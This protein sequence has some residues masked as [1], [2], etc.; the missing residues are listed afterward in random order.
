[1]DLQVSHNP[2]LMIPVKVCSL[3]TAF[4]QHFLAEWSLKIMRI[5]NSVKFECTFPNLVVEKKK[6]IP[7]NSCSF[8][9]CH[10][11]EDAQRDQLVEQ[12]GVYVIWIGGFHQDSR[13][14]IMLRSPLMMSRS[15]GSGEKKKR[16]GQISKTQVHWP[17]GIIHLA[18]SS[19]EILPSQGLF[20]RKEIAK[21]TEAVQP[22]C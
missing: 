11:V 2:G 17:F 7:L 8:L 14:R 22:F 3:F 19:V 15:A 20:V 6:N 9:S 5:W 4:W 13:F 16:Q 1:M 10:H 12:S 18:G 21:T